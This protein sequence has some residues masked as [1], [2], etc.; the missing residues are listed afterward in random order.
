ML[1]LSTDEREAVEASRLAHK[2]AKVKVL[3]VGES[4]PASGKFFY[5]NE[6]ILHTA[7]RVAFETAYGRRSLGL[8][9]FLALFMDTGCYLEDLCH[10]PINTVSGER[11]E[12]A[13]IGGVAQL[14]KKMQDWNPPV[15]I[16]VM[17]EIN[18]LVLE[19][20]REAKISPLCF[21]LPFPTFHRT[22]YVR[23]L[24]EILS[25]LQSQGTI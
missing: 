14:S 5:I 13:R 18:A 24:S 4:P 9:E 16:S 3:F 17:M 25:S 7:T 20:V 10:H 11:K 8:S 21:S 19:A 12:S 2:P 15:I 1:D 23:E 22:R 6:T